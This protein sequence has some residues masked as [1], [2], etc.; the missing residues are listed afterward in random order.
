MSIVDEWT[1]KNRPSKIASSENGCGLPVPIFNRNVDMD[2]GV[3]THTGVCIYI[4]TRG[5]YQLLG[6]DMFRDLTTRTK[7]A[8]IYDIKYQEI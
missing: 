8:G 2:Q 7:M 6:G 3:N 1:P 4:Y 5:K